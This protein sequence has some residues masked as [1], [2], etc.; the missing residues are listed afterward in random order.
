[1]SG[2]FDGFRAK[3]HRFH[4]RLGRVGAGLRV[5]LQ[6]G[7]FGPPTSYDGNYLPLNG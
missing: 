4:V 2:A 6:L 3:N 5:G 7:D 1:M